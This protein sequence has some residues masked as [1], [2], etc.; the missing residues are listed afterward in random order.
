MKVFLGGTC[1]KTTWREDLIKL[2]KDDTNINWFNPVV[3]DWT[4]EAQ[5]VEEYEKE[6]S[7]VLLFVITSAMT[8][9][10]SIAEAVDCSN[11]CP[12]RTV[13]LVVEEGFDEGQLKSLKAVSDLILNNGGTVADDLEDVAKY[14][15]NYE[16]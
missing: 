15:K 14:L 11:K 5:K 1:N 7:D 4:E 13:F 16:S 6:V 2:C 9:V 8:G 3:D 12:D 10:F